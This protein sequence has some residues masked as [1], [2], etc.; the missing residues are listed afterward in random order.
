MNWRT[1]D[2]REIPIRDLTDEHLINVLN[3]IRT[4]TR[5]LQPDQAVA[6]AH[7]HHEARRR[8]LKWHLYADHKLRDGELTR[9]RG[10]YRFNGDMT[11]DLLRHR[12]WDLSPLSTEEI[13]A[14]V[15]TLRRE[16]QKRYK[17]GIERAAE[18]QRRRREARIAI[19]AIQAIREILAGLDRMESERR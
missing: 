13:E 10:F 19:Q 11:K 17:A 18:E 2:G 5:N 1:G 7:L 6:F 14:Y 15:E 9:P 4:T 8:G 12:M 3:W 16:Q